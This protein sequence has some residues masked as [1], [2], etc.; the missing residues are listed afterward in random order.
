M[1]RPDH[2]REACGQRSAEKSLRCA[3]VSRKRRADDRVGIP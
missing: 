3:I 1:Y 2:F